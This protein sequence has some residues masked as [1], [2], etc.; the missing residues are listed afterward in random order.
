MSVQVRRG[1]FPALWH[2]LSKTQKQLS[3][4]LTH[5]RQ[6]LAELV[7]KPS[8]P[9]PKSKMRLKWI[10]CG[11][12]CNIGYA[13]DMYGLAKFWRTTR[14]KKVNLRWRN[15]ALIPYADIP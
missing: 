7:Q 11:E 12:F 3:V 8:I 6:G 2:L 15:K 14:A 5:F 9:S 1:L 13:D 4:A 10:T